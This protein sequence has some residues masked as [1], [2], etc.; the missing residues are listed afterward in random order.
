MGHMTRDIPIPWRGH[1]RAGRNLELRAG[2]ARDAPRYLELLHV[3]VSE[4]RNML[5]TAADPLPDASSQRSTID[6]LARRDNAVCVVASRGGQPGKSVLLGCA[7]LIGG[8]SRATLHAAELAM[9]VRREAWG[10]GIGGALLDA[11]LTWARK[12]SILTRVSLQVYA[13]NP[14]AI[15]LYLSRGFELEGRHRNYARHGEERIDLIGMG[16]S[17]LPGAAQ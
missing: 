12:G 6:G 16:I 1:D 14:A 15:A 10:G 7:T 9:G 4:T 11:C 3:L 5:Q 13:D 2:V 17:L 8:R